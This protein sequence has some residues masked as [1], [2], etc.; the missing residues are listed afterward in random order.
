MGR[1]RKIVAE[2]LIILVFLLGING[3]EDTPDREF[4][5]INFLDVSQGDCILIQLPDHK[6]MLID[7]GGK[8]QS[9][10][11]VDFIRSKDITKL[12]DVYKRQSL[13]SPFIGRRVTIAK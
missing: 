4:V 12:E 1:K 11:V 9:Q 5:C 6:T 2:L 10:F 8:D 13:F 7:A 3:C